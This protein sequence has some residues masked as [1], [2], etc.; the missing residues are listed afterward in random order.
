MGWRC[1]S[2]Y[3]VLPLAEDT[4]EARTALREQLRCH[5]LAMDGE[6]SAEEIHAHYLT[7]SEEDL[8]KDWKPFTS[9]LQLLK[10]YD[11]LRIYH[12]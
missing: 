11:G 3:S 8:D 7:L 6:L 9:M 12:L 5:A 1:G 2:A 10:K 4:P